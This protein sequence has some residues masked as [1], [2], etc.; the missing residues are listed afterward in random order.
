MEVTKQRLTVAMNKSIHYLSLHSVFLT[1]DD[2]HVLLCGL[3]V[4]GWE[5]LTF[6]DMQLQLAWQK[7]KPCIFKSFDLKI[8]KIF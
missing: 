5:E 4:P 8:N 6:Y 7:N 3:I 2:L 1:S